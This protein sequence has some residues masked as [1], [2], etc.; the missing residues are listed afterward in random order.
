MA[1][2]KYNEGTVPVI[3]C[4]NMATKNLGVDFDRLIA[5]LQ[6]FIDECFAP[7]W[8]TPAKLTK[9]AVDVPS[10]WNMIFFDDALASGALGFHDL[11]RYGSP[12]LKVFVIPS[13][14]AG[15]EIG[16]AASQELAAA[17]IDPAANLWADGPGG[18]LYAYDPCSAV[19]EEKF[20]IDGIA[21][22]NFVYPSYFENFRRPRPVQFDYLKKVKMPFDILKGG[23]STV[24]S[25]NKVKEIFGSAAKRQRFDKQ[26]HRG[27][28]S[29]YRR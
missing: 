12:V 1:K 20:L 9:R 19:D 27:V 15:I 24:R 25:G 23:Y 5:A 7:V 8:G 21:M 10:A 4:A 17:L 16:V 28:R 14:E 29:Q 18:A 22:S 2:T 13:L 11:T 6:R 26:N 3:R